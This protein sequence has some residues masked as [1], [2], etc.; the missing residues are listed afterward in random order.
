MVN[1]EKNCKLNREWEKLVK[2]V[3]S[4]N[5]INLSDYSDYL[6]RKISKRCQKMVISMILQENV[7]LEIINKDVLCRKLWIYKEIYNQVK[8]ELTAKN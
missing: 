7:N 6:L 2:L 3:N 8:M 1:L 4:G 5:N